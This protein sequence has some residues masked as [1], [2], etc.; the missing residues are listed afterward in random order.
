MFRQ[1]GETAGLRQ[2][3]DPAYLDKLQ[4]AEQGAIN[5]PATLS[6]LVVTGLRSV[7][8][9]VGY[10]RV[11]VNV[12]LPGVAFLLVAAAPA[13]AGQVW[14]A[15]RRLAASEEV[16]N[17]Y[18]WRHSYRSL[19]T[20]PAAAKEIRLFG[21]RAMLHQRLI[22]ALDAVNAGEIGAERSAAVVHGGLAVAGELVVGAGLIG[23]LLA[24]W[25]SSQIR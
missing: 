1:A 4:L 22:D 10:I 7:A 12:W 19:L 11:L 23:L 17:A 15:R 8:M 16:A 18:R 9:M 5:A 14:V 20:S 21:L 6:A 3:E 13:I 24:K 2:V 25:S